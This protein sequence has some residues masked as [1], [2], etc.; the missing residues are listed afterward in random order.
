VS[1]FAVIK[2]TLL[3]PFMA[4]FTLKDALQH[5]FHCRG[6]STAAGGNRRKPCGS[7]R[8]PDFYKFTMGQLIWRKYASVQ[9][10]FSFINRTPQAK[11]G[12]VLDVGE[13]REQLDHARSLMFTNSELHY[14]HGT[15]EYRERMFDEGYLES[16]SL[17]RGRR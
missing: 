10:T 6:L 12:R 17:E 13:L 14:L 7:L 2:S 1:R 9:T 4:H 11:L 15:N 16:S 8:E 3:A 5:E